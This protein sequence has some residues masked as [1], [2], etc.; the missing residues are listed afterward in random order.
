MSDRG[1]EFLKMDVRSEI[2]IKDLFW[3]TTPLQ[4]GNFALNWSP[5]FHVAMIWI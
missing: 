5:S 2:G 4:N 1:R 3:L